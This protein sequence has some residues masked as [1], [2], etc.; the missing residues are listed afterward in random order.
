MS[1]RQLQ[2]ATNH[3]RGYAALNSKVH[4]KQ[5]ESEDDEE[6]VYGTHADKLLIRACMYLYLHVH[7]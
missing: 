3:T 2:S 1:G 6:V 5:D 4:A 7:V